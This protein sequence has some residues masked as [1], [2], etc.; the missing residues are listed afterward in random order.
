MLSSKTTFFAVIMIV[1]FFFTMVA[2]S[3]VAAKDSTKP[4]LEIH[5]ELTED[6]YRAL[7]QNDSPDSKTL[8]TNLS[9]NYLHQIAVCARY[10]VETNLQLLRQQ[11]R[12]IE[13]LKKIKEQKNSR[14]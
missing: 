11:D 3:T 7:S 4:P 13:L 9:E 10:T 12:I 1:L 6:F 8:S 2:I 5:L 14:P